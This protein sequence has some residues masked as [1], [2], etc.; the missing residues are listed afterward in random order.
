MLRRTPNREPTTAQRLKH[1]SLIL[2]P[3][4]RSRHRQNRRR[5]RSSNHCTTP[6]KQRRIHSRTNEIRSPAKPNKI[7]NPLRNSIRK[8]DQNN[9]PVFPRPHG[10]PQIH[11]RYRLSQTDIAYPPMHTQTDIALDRG[12]PT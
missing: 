3:T 2:R 9:L 10:K 8:S 7:V 5:N 4:I 12:K 6:L 1:L 11:N